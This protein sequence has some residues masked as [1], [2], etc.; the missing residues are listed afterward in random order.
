MV[1]HL[2]GLAGDP[3]GAD[4]SAGHHPIGGSPPPS[5]AGDCLS[6]GHV[7]PTAIGSS[8][9]RR[10]EAAAQRPVSG[11]VSGSR[12]ASGPTIPWDGRIAGVTSRLHHVGSSAADHFRSGGVRIQA[13]TLRR[14]D[15]AGQLRRRQGLL[16]LNQQVRSSLGLHVQRSAPCQP[17]RIPAGPGI[18]L[19][20]VPLLGRSA[21]ALAE[22]AKPAGG[23]RGIA[24]D[25]ASY[26]SGQPGRLDLD[27][28]WS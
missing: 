12:Q 26:R 27:Q 11:S 3:L 15:P 4:R 14:W 25:P 16:T 24:L 23:R 17:G 9:L 13:I 5:I 21:P 7:T 10:V 18:W 8:R 2:Q 20:F 19:G 28:A 1:R 6:L 22:L